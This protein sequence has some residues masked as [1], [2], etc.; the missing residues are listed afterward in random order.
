MLQYHSLKKIR[1]LNKA[2]ARTA[3]NHMRQLGP[4]LPF[5]STVESAACVVGWFVSLLVHE[6]VLLAGLCEK[7]ILFRL[8]IYDS[9]RRVTAKRIPANL[10]H[11]SVQY[12]HFFL[13]NDEA[14]PNHLK[15]NERYLRLL[16]RSCSE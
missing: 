8:K 3:Q 4:T 14:P 6:E 9:S 10:M 15:K 12:H 1:Q 5:H 13:K 2:L 16:V 11:L 7:K